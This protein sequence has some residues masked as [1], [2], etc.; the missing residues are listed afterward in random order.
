MAEHSAA[1]VQNAFPVY[2]MDHPSSNRNR[3]NDAK[4]SY[5][6]MLAQLSAFNSTR[7]TLPPAAEMSG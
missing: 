5:A 3:L 6:N 7:V 1:I 4:S 2:P